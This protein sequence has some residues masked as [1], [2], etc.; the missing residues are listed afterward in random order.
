MSIEIKKQL[1]EQVLKL[2]DDKISILHSEFNVYKDSAAN[3]TK[4]TAGDKHDTSKSMMQL[5]QEKMSAQ[6]SDILSQKKVLQTISINTVQ[7]TIGL[8]SLVYT[9]NGNF[10]LSIF[11]KPI[12][13]NQVN[14]FPVSIQ[15]PIGKE[16]IKS[17]KGSSIRIN[18][19]EYT[20]LGI[21]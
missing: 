7:K 1:L 12:I 2:I 8:G 20:I 13:L 5:E 15:S 6:L 4:S 3:E 16:L 11:S 10:F 19:K 21:V 18:N 17:Q 14:F 9:N